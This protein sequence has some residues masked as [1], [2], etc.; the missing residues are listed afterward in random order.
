M[1]FH[2]SLSLLSS[3]SSFQVSDITVCL[4]EYTF[5][6]KNET[7][8][9]DFA[10]LS[11]KIHEEYDEVTYHNDIAV[12]T[13][14]RSTEFNVDVW[15]ICLP[16]R[17]ETYDGLQGTV[18]GELLSYFIFNFTSLFAY[19]LDSFFISVFFLQDGALF[20]SAVLCPL[21]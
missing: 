9:S 13:L 19:L 21:C 16:N 1:Q 5:D 20:T 4:G 12:I 14:E 6:T 8:H 15:P 10:L 7:T 2:P 11:A 17:D 3:P 18:I